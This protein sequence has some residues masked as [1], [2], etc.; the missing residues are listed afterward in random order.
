MNDPVSFLTAFSGGLLS[1]FSPCVIVLLPAWLAWLAGVNLSAADLLPNK[2]SRLLI[3]SLWFALGFT[4]VFV[5]LGASLGWLTSWLHQSDLWLE[6]IGG[7]VMIMMGLVAAGLIRIPFFSQSHQ[8]GVAKLSGRKLAPWLLSFF[9]GV[10]FSVS[11]TPCVSPILAG[12]LVLAGVEGSIR[13][14]ILLLLFYSLGLVVPLVVISLA[15]DRAQKFLSARAKWFKI[16]NKI[17]GVILIIIGVLLL[18]GNFSRWM[19][20]L[21]N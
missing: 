9:G 17:V 2:S 12:I 20:L 21:G 4:L 18:T 14:G 7:L 19:S 1:F 3:S 10:I 16:V 5:A 15:A 8:T 13:E 6:R 11:W